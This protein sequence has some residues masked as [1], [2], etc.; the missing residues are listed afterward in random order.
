MEP[1]LRKILQDKDKCK[2]FQL[3][4]KEMKKR[5]RGEENQSRT[6][7]AGNRSTRTA[8]FWLVEFLK[9]SLPKDTRVELLDNTVG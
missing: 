9:A 4:L 8:D 6:K 3:L 7:N 2:E 5:L 1:K